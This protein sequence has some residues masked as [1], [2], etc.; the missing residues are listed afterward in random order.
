MSPRSFRVP[1]CVEESELIHL[2]YWRTEPPILSSASQVGF[3]PF[4]EVIGLVFRFSADHEPVQVFYVSNTF[5][6]PCHVATTRSWSKSHG[7]KCCYGC[8]CRT[9]HNDLKVLGRGLSFS[10]SAAICLDRLLPSSLVS[11]EL[12]DLGAIH[13]LHNLVGL[14]FLEAE[15]KAFMRVV[16]VIGLIF[17]VFD[18]DEIRVLGGRVQ[19]ERHQSVDGGSLRDDLKGPG[20]C[21]VSMRRL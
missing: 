4:P 17:V 7:L 16:L 18:L 15:A 10:R 20:L 14:P 19:G 11:F 1:G 2:F 9:S 6:I 12:F 8:T 13:V 21:S 5:S 3:L